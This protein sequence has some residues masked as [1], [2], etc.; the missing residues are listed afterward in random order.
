MPQDIGFDLPFPLNISPDLER[1]RSRNL[2]WVRE[3]GLV[4]TGEMLAWYSM[5]D[6]PK[7]AAYGFPYAT[8][9]ELDLCTDAMAFFFLFDDQFDG[10]LGHSPDRVAHA[11]RGFTDLIH[12]N[13]SGRS[14]NPL[15]NAFADVW[16][17]CRQS[18]S[19]RWQA[20]AAC[21]WEY[22]FAAHAHEA[23]NRVRGVP[24]PMPEYVEVRRGV[25][26]MDITISLGERAAMIDVPPAAFYSP[27]LRIMRQIAVELP[28]MCNDVYS[29]E[30]EESRGDMDNLVLVLEQEQH[31]SRTEAIEQAKAEIARRSARFLS[32]QHGVAGM[33][34][35][36]GLNDQQHSEVNRY[37][38]VM[39]AF[40][41]GYHQWE[42]ETR[43]Y[44]G[45][46]DIVPASGP[47][48]F[49]DLLD[50]QT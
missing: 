36:L 18:A 6:M 25:A 14:T 45:A 24:S 16:D 20:R 41:R 9:D 10:P 5:W 38:E 30:K 48:Y 13:R 44:T 7:L 1:A 40:T 31:I 43:R 37:I 39:S 11:C 26:A 12:G 4:D 29:L 35:Q 28:F 22:Y 50:H 42:T 19:A 2:D 47:G 15:T 46:A 3:Q 27:H 33:C 32:L 23:I 8:G 17:R 34:A 21:D 49:Q